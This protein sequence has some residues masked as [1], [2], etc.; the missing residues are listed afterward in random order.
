MAKILPIGP[1]EIPLVT[2]ADDANHVLDVKKYPYTSGAD[3]EDM[4]V[5]P[6]VHK[7]TVFVNGDQ[8]DREYLAIH[9]WFFA[10][11]NEP[12]DVYHPDY[13]SLTGYI[14]NTA[15]EHPPR[16][17]RTCNISFDFTEQGI[18][19]ANQAFLN[20]E[21]AA[22]AAVVE[23]SEAVAEDMAEDMAQAGVPDVEGEDWSLLDKWSSMGDAARAFA[24]AAQKAVGTITGVIS[25]VQAPADAISSTIDFTTTLSG[26]L[27]KSILECVEAYV[28]MARKVQSQTSLKSNSKSIIATLISDIND[29]K[30]SLRDA[31]DSVR[32]GYDVIGASMIAREAAR[33]ISEDESA[34]SES[35]ANESIETEDYDGNVI[36]EPAAVY[37]LTPAEVEDVLAMVRQAI[38]DVLA[39]GGSTD[40]L[41]RQAR[42]LAETVR[43]VK[44]QYMTTRT[45]V[46]TQPTP[47]HKLLV[48]NGLSYRAA[49]RVA[50]LNEIKNPTFMNGEVLIYAR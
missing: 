19:A 5:D 35:V 41:K 47:I 29:L 7:F 33:L 25:Q 34:Y 32:H 46:L 44:L 11:L 4:G 20:V 3:I 50:A 38:Q 31:P 37:L 8:Y 14:G 48:D 45:I 36:S 40:S 9:D 23:V 1:W 24:T 16:Q 39:D 2:F 43:R 27:T 30:A 12:V 18:R 22:E 26:R 42:D 49:D 6:S 21:A 13:G 10:R 15:F 17:P 28:V